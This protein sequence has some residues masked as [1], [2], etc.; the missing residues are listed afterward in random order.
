MNLQGE[1]HN[2]FMLY[3][4][5]GLE[6]KKSFISSLLKIH[7]WINWYG[8]LNFTV[9]TIS[10]F[11]YH[12]D[13]FIITWC[14]LFVILIIF[15]NNINNIYSVIIKQKTQLAEYALL[16]FIALTGFILR[17]N[18]YDFHSSWYDE[19]YSSVIASDPNKPFIN[20]FGDPGNPP[21]YFILLR[22]WFIIFGWTEQSGRF[23]SIITGT[24]AIIALY[25]LIK[26]FAN[27]KA[28]FMAVLY[29]SVSEY[30]IGFSQETRSYILVVLLAVISADRFLIIIKNQN[31]TIKNLTG[32]IIPTILLVNTHYYGILMVFASFLF[33]VIY[34]T[35]T[36]TL[37]KKKTI[38]FFAGNIIIALSFLPY[39]FYTALNKA[40]LDQNFNS[41]IQKPGR[42]FIYTALVIVLLGAM[43][44]YK[45]KFLYTTIISSSCKIFINYALFISSVIYLIAFSIS[46]YRPLLERKY[47]II[48]YPF[49]IAVV[50]LI[51]LKIIT[52]FID[53]TFTNKAK[54]FT[55][56]FIVFFVLLLILNELDEPGGGWDLY[57]EA[58]AYIS[59]DSD[60]NSQLI[61]MSIDHH[62][63]VRSFAAFYGYKELPFYKDGDK[64][65]VIY[66]NPIHKNDD[67][68]YSKLDE[69]GIKYNQILKIR[70]NE[71]KNVFKIYSYDLE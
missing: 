25:I 69:F 44:L 54:L 17:I 9:K 39:F 10:Y 67:F 59:K 22:V 48:L 20:T 40:L 15:R 53:K 57:Q 38:V 8:D 47:I 55:N 26:R 37:T 42:D 4:L 31:L 3:E 23:L 46:F 18:G 50:A 34:L 19:L 70:I 52:I 7:P 56:I 14:F 5:R 36:K 58:Q 6:Y 68:I 32:Y 45:R 63:N 11:I 61:N 2:G 71:Q 62:S 21:F 66:F 12:P 24:A 35:N 28:A 51:L 27:K 13:K 43:Y 1:E 30:F 29:M 60:A 33:F 64:Y 49:I 65:N 16:C 41:W